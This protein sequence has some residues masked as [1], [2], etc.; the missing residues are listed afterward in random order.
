VIV[1]V[2]VSVATSAV[3]DVDFEI[4]AICAANTAGGFEEEEQH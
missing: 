1:W 2:C 4:L 3:S